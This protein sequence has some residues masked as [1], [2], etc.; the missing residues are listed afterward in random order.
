MEFRDVIL[1]LHPVIAVVVV[2]PLIGI[3][4]NRALQTRQRRLQTASGMKSKIP[5]SAGQEHVQLGRWLTGAV[6]GIVLLGLANDV[7]NNIIDTKVWEQNSV[8]VML[9][10][11]LFGVAIASLALLYRAKMRLW[12]G[13]FATLAG[14]SLVVLGCQDGI[15]RRTNQWYVSHYYYGITAALLMIFSLAIL[16]EIYQDKTNRWRTVHIVLNSIALLI[17]FGQ[18]ITGTQ[19]L[20]EVPLAWQEPYVNKLYEQQCDKKPCTVQAAPAP[21]TSK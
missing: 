15:Y 12:R 4:V 5:P 3:V 6:V 10:I 13:V 8:K 20:L 9:I 2:F 14:M 11:T 7:F 18:G 19:A 21:Q 17:F 1:L 16:R